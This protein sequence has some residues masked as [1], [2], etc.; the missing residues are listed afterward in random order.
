M[1]IRKSQ[2]KSKPPGEW[3]KIPTTENN[4]FIQAN[5]A[6]LDTP[7]I[8]SEALQGPQAKQWQEAMNLEMESISKNNTWSLTELPPERKPID[9]K[10]LFKLKLKED[11]S[12]EKFKAWLVAKGFAQ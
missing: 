5:F 7:S 8:T 1:P 6:S 11:R 9:C 4:D 10:W 3:W 2:R 12:I